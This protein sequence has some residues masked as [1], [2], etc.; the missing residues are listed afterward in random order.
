MLPI[1]M[2]LIVAAGVEEPVRG[3]A[4]VCQRVIHHLYLIHGGEIS[5]QTMP[6]D[7]AERVACSA[8]LLVDHV[9]SSDTVIRCFMKVWNI[10]DFN[11]VALLGMVK[12]GFC[13]N[14]GFV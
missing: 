7:V 5:N 4:W 8:D 13:T 14:G 9:T 11:K 12:Q 2:P 10:S 3:E 1:F 6:R